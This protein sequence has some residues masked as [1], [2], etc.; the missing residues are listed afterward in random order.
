[1]DAWKDGKLYRSDELKVSAY[2]HGFL[3]GLGFFETFR[4]YNGQVFLWKEHWE[5][6]SRALADFRVSMPY[7][8]EV[9]LKAI[10]EL[11]KA[12]SGEDGYFRL[13]ISAGVHDIGLQPSHYEKPTMIL[14]RKALP[15][16]N[17]GTEKHAVW[18]KT[19][20]N[21]PESMNRHKSHHYANNIQARFEVETL[22][23][24]EGF[25]LTSDGF[26]AEGI[27]SNIF[28]A[29]DGK[30]Y[31]P[32][33]KT[34]ILA[35]IT[36]HWILRSSLIEVEEGFFTKDEVESADE[37]F[38]TNA[39]QEIVPIQ[40]VDEIQYLGNQGPIYNVLHEAYIRCV[41]EEGIGR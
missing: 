40:Q 26:I 4:T 9:V 35:G 22:A 11:T 15:I 39:V 18:L 34:G 32:S 36:R 23:T 7:E 16:A 24:H 20:R 21:S 29:K 8:E 33:L 3:Y 5:R 19:V 28:W 30:V 41:Q 1:M 13:N 12:N 2:D 31:T 17:R 38:I 14:F 6:L 27:T 10:E 25:F 37:V